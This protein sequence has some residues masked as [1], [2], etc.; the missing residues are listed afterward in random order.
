MARNKYHARKCEAFGITFDSQAERNRYFQLVEMQQ[1]GIIHH[2]RCHPEF[3]LLEGFRDIDGKSERA[4]KYTADFAYEDAVTGLVVVED[5]KSKG[6]AASR[7]W[8]L[9][10]K[11]F[12]SKFPTMVLREVRVA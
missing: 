7:D 2:L 11:L 12:K 8:S 5:V 1:D 6:T 10:R 4:I 3:V 9:R